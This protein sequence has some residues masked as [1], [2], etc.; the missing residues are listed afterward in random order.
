MRPR[1]A[2]IGS[3]SDAFQ[4]RMLAFC[5]ASVIIPGF[6]MNKHE[7]LALSDK[8]LALWDKSFSIW[9]NRDTI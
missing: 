5:G 6:D 2:F 7:R 9:D 8:D 1:T 4:S 3:N